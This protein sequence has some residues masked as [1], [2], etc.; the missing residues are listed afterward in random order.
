MSAGSR[1]ISHL[2]FHSINQCA[3][4]TNSASI[5]VSI[6][7]FISKGNAGTKEREREREERN[8]EKNYYLLDPCQLLIFDA[9]EWRRY[10]F[11]KYWKKCTFELL[12]DFAIIASSCRASNKILSVY[13]SFVDRIKRCL[14]ILKAIKQ[15][16]KSSFFPFEVR[17][18]VARSRYEEASILD[19][20]FELEF[21]IFLLS[22]FFSHDRCIHDRDTKC[23]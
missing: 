13:I 7:N 22:S 10:F 15:V 8:K 18:E 12:L 2:H 4:E 5:S 23:S 9:T 6:S 11:T 3:D 20:R 1:V 14:E 19:R 17:R 21:I 16:N